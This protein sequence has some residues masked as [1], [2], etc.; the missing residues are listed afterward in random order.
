M[1]EEAVLNNAYLLRYHTFGGRETILL[2]TIPRWT[3]LDP[4]CMFAGISHADG[5]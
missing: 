1:A 5:V 2:D 3:F 4:G